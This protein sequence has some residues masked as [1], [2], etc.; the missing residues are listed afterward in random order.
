MGGIG[1]RQPGPVQEPRQFQRNRKTQPGADID[2][3]QIA[4]IDH[5]VAGHEIAVAWAIGR[6]AA[7]HAVGH[8]QQAHAQPFRRIAQSRRQISDGCGRHHAAVMRQFQRRRAA[9][10]FGIPGQPGARARHQLQAAAR[11]L[12]QR[13]GSRH[14]VARNLYLAVEAAFRPAAAQSRHPQRRGLKARGDAQQFGRNGRHDLRRVIGQHLLD[15]HRLIVQP[16]CHHDPPRR[17]FQ[18]FINRKPAQCGIARDCARSRT[19]ASIPE[20]T[21]GVRGIGTGRPLPGIIVPSPRTAQG[22]AAAASGGQPVVGRG[23]CVCPS[24][25][26]VGVNPPQTSGAEG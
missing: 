21:W 10:V 12:D 26:Q 14:R 7:G 16:S 18:Q 17:R 20:M 25:R 1:D 9:I 3:P 8:V 4:A 6:H 15:N 11:R 23:A 2:P 5:Q 24:C 19:T 22:G 13:Q